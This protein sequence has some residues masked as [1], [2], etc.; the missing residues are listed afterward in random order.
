[1]RI[2]FSD[3]AV[4][5]S[6]LWKIEIISFMPLVSIIIPIYNA[7]STLN[8]CV[9]SILGSQNYTEYELLLIDDGST[10]GSGTICDEYVAK[11]S[12]VRVFHKENGGVSSARNLGLDNARG[13]WVTFIDSD[14]YVLPSYL[15]RL[16]SCLDGDW[17]LGGYKESIG[18]IVCPIGDLYEGGGVIAFLNQY[19][20]VHV[21]RACWGGLY[22]A[23]IIRKHNIKFSTSIRYGED[24]YFNSCYM[25]HC[26]RIRLINDSGYIYCNEMITDDKY[27][28]SAADVRNTLSCIIQNRI[29]IENKYGLK[30]SNDAD[31]QI[32][33]NK[34]PI[35]ELNDEDSLYDY[36]S[37]CRKC[38]PDI[39]WENFCSDERCSPIVRLISIIKRRFE[40]HEN[41]TAIKCCKSYSRVCRVIKRCPRFKYK[42]FYIWYYL[43]RGGYMKILEFLM[44]F[45]FLSKKIISRLR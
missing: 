18:P 25:I 1:M 20:G 21:V 39:S 37:L 11:D 24:T 15:F 17:V 26:D 9:D 30:I 33:L 10:D 31:A 22:R 29:A 28:L 27:I 16:T 23:S 40:E 36:Y 42:D 35:E 44:K 4:L 45:Y 32:F 7:C 34:Y 41:D 12:R 43:L 5:K 14:D 8:R 2:C 13:E 38:Y 6:I 3:E 19:V